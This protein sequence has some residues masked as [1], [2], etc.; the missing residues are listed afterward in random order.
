[1]GLEVVGV[2]FGRRGCDDACYNRS[3][4]KIKFDEN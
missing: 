4:G 2:C 1:M 3:L